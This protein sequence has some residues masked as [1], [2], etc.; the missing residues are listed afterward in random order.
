[1]PSGEEIHQELKPSKKDLISAGPCKPP[2]DV[3]EFHRPFPNLL[4]IISQ[5]CEWRKEK[6]P[7]IRAWMEAQPFA[8]ITFAVHR[9]T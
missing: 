9:S 6:N 4:D 1:M 8:L 7:P 5:D 2:D 3:G